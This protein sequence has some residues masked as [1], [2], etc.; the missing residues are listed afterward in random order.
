MT[1]Y[2]LIDKSV[3]KMLSDGKIDQYDIPELILLITQLSLENLVPTSTEDLNGKIIEL[4]SYVM[5]KYDLYPKN[6]DERLVFDRI[7]QSSIKLVLFQPIIKTK[8][9]QFWSGLCK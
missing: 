4:Y 1:A 6:M 9:N 3:Q 2:E 7:F 5:K 8:C